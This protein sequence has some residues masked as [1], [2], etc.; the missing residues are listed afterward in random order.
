MGYL[1]FCSVLAVLAMQPEKSLTSKWSMEGSGSGFDP[2]FSGAELR[3]DDDHSRESEDEINPGLRFRQT[4]YDVTKTRRFQLSNEAN[5]LE[6]RWEIPFVKIIRNSDTGFRFEE[7]SSKDI[8]SVS[9]S[10]ESS[11]SKRSSL[12]SA[13]QRL[14]YFLTRLSDLASTTITNAATTPGTTT[15]TPATTTAPPAAGRSIILEWLVR[16]RVLIIERDVE[17]SQD[18]PFPE[19]DTEESRDFIYTDPSHSSEFPSTFLLN[20]VI[21]VLNH[22]IIRHIISVLFH[23]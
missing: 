9:K 22:K 20:H 21:Y 11:V 10:V 1:S 6:N 8:E 19:G 15:V 3:I 18:V 7:E 16:Y 13:Q 2:D 4:P 12:P 17:T 23:G 5:K 14:R